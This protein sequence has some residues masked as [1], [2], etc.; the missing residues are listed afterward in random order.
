MP[1]TDDILS[2]ATAILTI[3]F[4]IGTLLSIAWLGIGAALLQ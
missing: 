4:T 1:T 2:T 3:V